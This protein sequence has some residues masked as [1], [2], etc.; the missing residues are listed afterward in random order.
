MIWIALGNSTFLYMPEGFK[1]NIW[2]LWD[3]SQVHNDY[4]TFSMCYEWACLLG[5]CENDIFN[6]K[7]RKLWIIMFCHILEIFLML[8][9]SDGE[10]SSL[11]AFRTWTHTL[12][13][14]NDVKIAWMYHDA[15]TKSPLHM[16]S[17]DTHFKDIVPARIWFRRQITKLYP[18]RTIPWWE[19]IKE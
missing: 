2:H 13:R 14:S 7:C 6:Q 12:S 17:F 19:E 5:R 8:H 4:Q 3:A 1:R 11:K 15:K 18:T 16:S 9:R 10:K